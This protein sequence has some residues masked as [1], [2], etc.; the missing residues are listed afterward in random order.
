[1]VTNCG[2]INLLSNVLLEPY[3]MKIIS[4]FKRSNTDEASIAKKLPIDKAIVELLKNIEEQQGDEIYQKV[5]HF[6]LNMV[7]DEPE[8]FK[9]VQKNHLFKN[10]SDKG[11]K[12]EE[13]QPEIV[14]TQEKTDAPEQAFSCINNTLEQQKPLAIHLPVSNRLI[15]KTPLAVKVKLNP[16][17]SNLDDKRKNN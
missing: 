5:N 8:K 1:M 10:E 9:C 14:P 12:L 6:L 11:S 13:K 3:Q 17:N 16:S 2:N 4:H 15:L 7:S